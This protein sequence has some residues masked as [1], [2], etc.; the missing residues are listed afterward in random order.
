M[1]RAYVDTN[2]YNQGCI[3]A[4]IGTYKPEVVDEKYGK[5]YGEAVLFTTLAGNYEDVTGAYYPDINKAAVA[6]DGDFDS[7]DGMLYNNSITVAY[8][9]DDCKNV[10]ELTNQSYGKTPQ[11]YS[12]AIYAD[13]Y[14]YNFLSGEY[15]QIFK[16][17]DTISGEELKKYIMD[18]SLGLRYDAGTAQLNSTTVFMPKIT[19]KGEKIDVRN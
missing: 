4:E 5:I 10:T 17:S 12:S 3:W 11:G 18:N 9:F 14:A 1:E 7:T 8:S 16:D 2:V 13:V 19:A 15:E 6:T